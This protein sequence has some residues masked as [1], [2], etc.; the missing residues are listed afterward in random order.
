M[1]E[2]SS[3]IPG[4]ITR[5]I[6]QFQ[7]SGEESAFEFVYERINRLVESWAAHRCK[8][9]K[10]SLKDENDVAS[11][12]WLPLYC[13]NEL[14]FQ[15]RKAL[16][17]FLRTRTRFLSLNVI[18]DSS[19]G[20]TVVRDGDRADESRVPVSATMTSKGEQPDEEVGFVDLTEKIMSDL[21]GE[22]SDHWIIVKLRMEGHSVKEIA[23]ILGISERQV[24]RLLDVIKNI[25]G[26]RLFE[27]LDG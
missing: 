11:E 13:R 26:E 19:A 22:E 24:Y 9:A 1:N 4:S 3:S 18:R 25:I 17:A 23:K 27:S 8:G 16:K 15:N 20:P 7:D 10:N 5:A 6:H 21:G 14:E 2:T 12:V